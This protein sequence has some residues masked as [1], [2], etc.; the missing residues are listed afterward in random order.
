M[1][2]AVFVSG[3]GTN[4]QRLLDECSAG[5]L[6]SCDIVQV[7][8]SKADTKA[9][10]RARKAG[11]P[12]AVLER[13]TFPDQS[14]YDKAL[15]ELLKPREIGLIVLAGFLTKLGPDFLACY[16]NRVLNI[17]PSL[18]PAFGGAGFYGIRPHH[19]VLE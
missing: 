13:K 1:R 15:I 7:V 17:H 9:E 5:R 4:L 3:G 8:A 11:I 12:V 19:A 10:Q 6:P 16:P 14:S 18:L 2:V